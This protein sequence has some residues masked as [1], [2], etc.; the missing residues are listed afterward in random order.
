MWYNAVMGKCRHGMCE[1]P[2]YAAWANMLHRCRANY[3]R[4]GARGIVVCDEWG[5]FERFLEDVGPRPGPDRELD[6]IDNDG[7]YEPGNVRW[8]TKKEQMR[9]RSNTPMFLYRGEMKPLTEL[10]EISAGLSLNGLKRR[11]ASGK[12]TVES[13]V[14]T[15]ATPRH[16]RWGLHR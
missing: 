10:L 4:Y 15:P 7:N 14:H 2:E 3:K 12:W 6:R 8:A 5:S 1:T 9:N 16:L 13:A 11:L